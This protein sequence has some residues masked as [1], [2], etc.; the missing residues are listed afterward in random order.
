MKVTPTDTI[1]VQRCWKYVADDG[2]THTSIGST[3]PFVG[4]SPC[5]TRHIDPLTLAQC[6][7]T[8]CLRRQPNTKRNPDQRLRLAGSE[9]TIFKTSAYERGVIMEKMW[10]SRSTSEAIS[11]DTF[12]EHLF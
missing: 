9:Q 11:P 5:K 1:L 8:Y 12:D 6:W 3:I 4:G 10:Q 2:P 7:S